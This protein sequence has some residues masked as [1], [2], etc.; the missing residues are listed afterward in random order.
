MVH[1]CQ[2]CLIRPFHALRLQASGQ[3]GFA[4]AEQLSSQLER[5]SGVWRTTLGRSLAERLSHRWTRCPI[6]ARFG[7]FPG[8]GANAGKG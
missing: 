4:L 3:A 6:A 8:L 1:Q 7:G 2:A 5:L